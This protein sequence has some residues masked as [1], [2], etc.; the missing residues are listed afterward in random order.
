MKT[1]ILPVL[2]LAASPALAQAYKCTDAAGRVAFQEQP[3]AA[4]ARQATVKLAPVVE[5]TPEQKRILQA[6]AVGAVTAGMSAAQVRQV[7]GPPVRIN[8]TVSAGGVS[9]QWVYS[10][11]QYLYL[12]RGLVSA[13]QTTER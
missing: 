7:W 13:M 2:A 12:T 6:M 4:G 11:G 9:E 10:N 5:Q 1:L 8:K 3:C